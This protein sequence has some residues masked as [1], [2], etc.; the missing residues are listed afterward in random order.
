MKKEKKEKNDKRI[1]GEE[2][3]SEGTGIATDEY[4]RIKKK[5]EVMVFGGEFVSA[6]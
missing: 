3:T 4:G 6:F 2:R 5:N 1:I